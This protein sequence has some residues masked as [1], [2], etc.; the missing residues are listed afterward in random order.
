MY[1]MLILFNIITF[2]PSFTFPGRHTAWTYICIFANSNA[3]YSC[4]FANI[5]DGGISEVTTPSLAVYRSLGHEAWRDVLVG[6]HFGRCNS[7]KTRKEGGVKRIAPVQ[8]LGV[9]YVLPLAGF[10]PGTRRP[11]RFILRQRV[12][13]W[14]P[15]C[16]AVAVRFHRFLFKAS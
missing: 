5:S 15:S 11:R 6:A 7:M 13:L 3:P 1:N 2:K 4:N 8:R 9:D 10:D 16:F 12:L 14:T